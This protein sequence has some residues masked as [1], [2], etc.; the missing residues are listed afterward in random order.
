MSWLNLADSA[1]G[2]AVQIEQIKAARGS[3]AA[4]QQQALSQPQTPQ[5]VPAQDT[6]KP[7]APAGNK[8]LLMLAGGGALLLVGVVLLA[9]K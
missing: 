8:T 1:I 7:A 6:P 9:R 5:V 3:T 4:G 2:A